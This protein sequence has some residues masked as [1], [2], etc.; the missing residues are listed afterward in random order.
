MC[1]AAVV[2]SFIFNSAQEKDIKK[3]IAGDE[4]MN[5]SGNEHMLIVGLFLLPGAEIFFS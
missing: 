1:R 4:H 3:H 2:G 5:T